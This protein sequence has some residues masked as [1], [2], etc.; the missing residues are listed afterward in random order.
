MAA[1]VLR[2]AEH[3]LEG[4]AAVGGNQQPLAARH[5][6]RGVSRSVSTETSPSSRIS[7]GSLLSN[8]S[9]S[10]RPS[11]TIEKANHAALAPY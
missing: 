9:S 10:D 11:S 6:H 7:S 3:L 2:R 4:D 8:L 1:F 5:D